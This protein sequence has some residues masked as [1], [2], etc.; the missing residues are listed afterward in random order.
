MW[1]YGGGFVIGYTSFEWYDM[2]HLAAN[3]DVI[4]VSMNYRVNIF[5]HLH[6]GDERMNNSKYPPSGCDR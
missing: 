5:S 4:V 2:K 1:I 6:T 3:G